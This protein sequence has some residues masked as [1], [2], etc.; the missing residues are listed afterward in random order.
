MAVETGAGRANGLIEAL[1]RP[2][3]YPDP[4][5]SVELRE[6]HISW[7][8]L[9]DHFAYKLKKPVRFEFVDFSTPE[10]RYRAC[11]DELRLNRRWTR[12]VYLDVVPVL[13]STDGDIYVGTGPGRPIDWMVHMRR[14]PDSLRLDQRI[15]QGTLTDAERDRLVRTLATLY[16]DLPPLA[17]E[18]DEYRRRVE[19]HVR[20]NWEELRHAVGDLSELAVRRSQSQ[21]WR[22]VRL[23]GT[24]LADR[25]RDGRIVD[26]HGD[27]R[28]DHIYLEEPLAIVD[29]VEFRD[30]FRRI[31]ALDD[32]VFLV[33]E[34]RVL[35]EQRLG[36]QLIDAYRRTAEDHFDRRLYWFYLAYR[37]SVRAKV[38]W[39]K[40]RQ[41][42]GILDR[43]T[44]QRAATYLALADEA[45]ENLFPPLLI[46]LRG[47]SGSGKST[48]GKALAEELALQRVSTD[49]VRQAM[50][51]ASAHVHAWQAGRYQ[52]EYRQQVYDML[53]SRAEELLSDHLSVLVDGTFLEEALCE[54]AEQLARQHGAEV[55]FVEC[56]CDLETLRERLKARTPGQDAGSEADWQI[57][58]RQLELLQPIS[59][60]PQTIVDT[61][62][63]FPEQIESVKASL[64]RILKP[65]APGAPSR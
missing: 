59:S 8:F 16:R 11:Q 54:R 26:G 5:S 60:L 22:W 51:G 34:C 50:F 15:L 40:A 41:K 46:V 37:A 27:L 45:A 58:R 28:P 17:V 13:R 42:H 64:R 12:G 7:V 14:L 3:T 19:A 21:Q 55:L 44:L 47:V 35:E 30:D 29:C 43:P 57:A 4:T 49:E 65:P 32:L 10:A 18:A 1:L 24:T 48:L 9:T 38:L 62:A 61:R 20:G 6:T 39:L 53:F 33:M 36:K 2:E 31:D 25:A 52:P 63:S 23:F 56:Q